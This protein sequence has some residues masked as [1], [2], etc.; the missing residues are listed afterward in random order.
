MEYAIRKCEN[1]HFYLL[2][3]KFPVIEEIGYYL[4]KAKFNL[5]IN[6]G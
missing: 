6:F 4:A 3:F 1:T 5:D 2:P